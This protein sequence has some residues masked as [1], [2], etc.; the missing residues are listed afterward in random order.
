MKPKVKAAHRGSSMR[1]PDGVT[2]M[3]LDRAAPSGWWAKAVGSSETPVRI[4]V[5]HG[6]AEFPKVG[7]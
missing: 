7:G 4:L 6:F 1:C 3:L 5:R 2:R